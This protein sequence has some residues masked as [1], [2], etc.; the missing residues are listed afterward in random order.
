[1]YLLFVIADR[2]SVV[3]SEDGKIVSFFVVCEQRVSKLLD[4]KLGRNS[5]FWNT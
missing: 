5:F 3:V 2:N 4:V 1:M